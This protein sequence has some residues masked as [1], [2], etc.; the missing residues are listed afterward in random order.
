[1]K[2]R[3]FIAGL[4]S[5]AAWPVVA[6]AQQPTMPVI[7]RKSSGSIPQRAEGRTDNIGSTLEEQMRHAWLPTIIISIT[8]SIGLSA[9]LS[10]TENVFRLEETTIAEIHKAVLA[11]ALSSE[12]IVELYLAR[13]AAYDRAGPRLNSIMYINPNAKAEAAALDK[14]RA[15][16]GPRGPLHGPVLQCNTRAVHFPGPG[17]SRR[18][19]ATWPECSGPRCGRGAQRCLPDPER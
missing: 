2:R 13:I 9:G 7:V 8:S 4:G 5:A 18:S 11:G 15:E 12:K 17:I 1:M 19:D 14:E 3:L 10:A 6:R 16:K